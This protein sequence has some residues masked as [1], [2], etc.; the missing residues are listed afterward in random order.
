ME[1][2]AIRQTKKLFR[3]RER[4]GKPMP[5]VDKALNYTS[6]FGQDVPVPQHEKSDGTMALTGEKNPLP[7]QVIGGGSSGGSSSVDHTFQD[8]IAAAGDGTALEVTSSTKSYKTITLEIT[9]TSTS[10]TVVFEG[11]SASGAWYPIQ[12]VKLSNLA[13]GTQTTGNNEVWQF[14]VTGLASF[15]TRVSAVAG[16]NVTVKGKAVA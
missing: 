7:V 5:Q 8:A 15:R 2:G 16:G 4:G 11:S 3:Y 12:G 6:L 13:M 1:H 14:E 9:G 10:R